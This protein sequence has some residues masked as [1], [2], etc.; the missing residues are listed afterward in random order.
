M[1]D[2]QDMFGKKSVIVFSTHTDDAFIAIGGLMSGIMR[3]GGSLN[4][5]VFS[6]GGSL[7]LVRETG[8]LNYVRSMQRVDELKGAL[9][10]YDTMVS[11][12]NISPWLGKHEDLMSRNVTEK[13]VFDWLYESMSFDNTI[14][15]G[16]MDDGHQDHAFINRITKVIGRNPRNRC[17]T[18]LYALPYKLKIIPDFIFR[19]R[20]DDYEVKMRALKQF[21]S[22]L[23]S[24]D[25]DDIKLW[26]MMLG[27][28]VD[29]KFAEGVF[30][31][32]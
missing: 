31:L 20:S 11:G 14:L 12:F 3:Y 2:I 17:G 26:D 9:A 19:I 23:D 13:E 18:F 28:Y 25:V 21:E 1:I 30:C 32:R 16:P 22:V 8:A 15:F 6:A 27:K 24:K 29:S 10:E 4:L 5:V 7:K